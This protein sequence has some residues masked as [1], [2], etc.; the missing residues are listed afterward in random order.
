MDWNI[1]DPDDGW[2]PAKPLLEP[3]LTYCPLD[4]Y[5]SISMEFESIYNNFQTNACISE[6]RLQTSAIP[7]PHDVYID[8]LIQERRDSSALAME[9]RLSCTNPSIWKKQQ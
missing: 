7:P 3:M 9:L 1:I 8:G 2:F 6:C 4:S 5:Q